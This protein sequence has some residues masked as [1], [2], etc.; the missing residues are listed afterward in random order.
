MKI[1]KIGMIV[2]GIIIIGC[3]IPI[4]I[5]E[6]THWLYNL[7]FA[8][9]SGA[10]LSFFICLSNHIIYIKD[11]YEKL[12]IQVHDFSHTSALLICEFEHSK[13]ITD[14]Y[15]VT[16]QIYLE[17][18][19]IYY[20]NCLLITGLF[21]F[22]PRRNKLI[23]ID[24]DLKAII[25]NIF[26]IKCYVEKY[27]TEANNYLLQLY[28]DLKTKSETRLIYREYLNMAKWYSSSIRSPEIVDGNK[29]KYD[30]AEKYKLSLTSTQKINRDK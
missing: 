10:L 13:S 16:T 18:Y 11:S 26:N 22:D 25:K 20:L 6:Q 15:K 23:E 17:I 27:H 21:C 2:L 5:S 30:M 1:N 8:L 24:K 19:K 7:S 28:N 4:A 9:L 12:T 14:F 29:Y 3:I